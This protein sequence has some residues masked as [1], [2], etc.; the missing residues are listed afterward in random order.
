MPVEP[1][2]PNDAPI[3]LRGCDFVPPRSSNL[4]KIV[5]V[6]APRCLQN[7]IASHARRE[8]LAGDSLDSDRIRVA[9]ALARGHFPKFFFT[10]DSERSDR[11]GQAIAVLLA[12][13][14]AA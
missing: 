12:G 1:R 9:E 8:S 4:R 14:A 7:V 2:R 5:V 11:L 3:V 6:A 10:G 13:H